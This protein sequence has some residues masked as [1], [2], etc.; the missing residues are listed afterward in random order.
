MLKLN[1]LE[2]KHNPM[3]KMQKLKLLELKLKLTMVQMT[4]KLKNMMRMLTFLIILK[5]TQTMYV[6]LEDDGQSSDISNDSCHSEEFESLPNSD[7]E[8]DTNSKIVY[9]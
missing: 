6:S 7:D 9:P 4:M 5:V 3:Y 8:G 2:L 1:F